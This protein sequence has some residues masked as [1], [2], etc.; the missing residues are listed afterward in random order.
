M[1][2]WSFKAFCSSAGQ[3]TLSFKN[4]PDCWIGHS[5]SLWYQP[6]RFIL[7]FQHNGLPPPNSLS[8]IFKEW[9]AAKYNFNTFNQ[10]HILRLFHL[11]GNS[12][13][14]GVTWPGNCVWAHSQITF[15]L[16]EK[17]SMCVISKPH[18]V[19]L[20]ACMSITSCLVHRQNYK[21]CIFFVQD[22]ELNQVRARWK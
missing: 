15:D 18:K 1:N 8:H 21:S 6:D 2:L 5:K 13:R 14:T 3:S 9:K 17:E 7:V 22:I 10:L 16:L 4:V 20:N 11:S 19:K 12:K